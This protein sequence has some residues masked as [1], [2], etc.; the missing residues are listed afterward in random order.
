MTPPESATLARIETSLA[1]LTSE[2]I[3]MKGDIKDID[4][5]L[6]D[7]EKTLAGRIKPAAITSGISATVAALMFVFYVLD[8][9]YQGG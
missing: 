7:V 6:R 5:R 4:T 9:F 2:L 3:E 8:R 1:H